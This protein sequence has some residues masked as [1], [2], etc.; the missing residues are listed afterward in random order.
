MQLLGGL[1]EVLRGKRQRVSIAT[2]FGLVRKAG[3]YERRVDNTPAHIRAACEAS[4]RR[5]GVENID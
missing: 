1:A 5:L 4:L 3:G 2:K